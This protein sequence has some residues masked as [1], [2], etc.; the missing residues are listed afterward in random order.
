MNTRVDDNVLTVEAGATG[1]LLLGT[2]VIFAV[3]RYRPPLSFRTFGYTV[4]ICT[5]WC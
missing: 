1:L 5:D 2:R 4:E 3:V